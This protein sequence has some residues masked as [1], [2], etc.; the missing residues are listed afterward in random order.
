[1]CK[2]RTAMQYAANNLIS[3]I[4]KLQPAKVRL[5]SVRE[6]DTRTGGGVDMKKAAPRSR[7]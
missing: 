5:P 7:L 6:S 3:L 1:V 2:N 4:F